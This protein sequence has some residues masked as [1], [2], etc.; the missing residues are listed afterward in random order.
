MH[1]RHDRLLLPILREKWAATEVRSTLSLCWFCLCWFYHDQVAGIKA[2]AHVF[3]STGLPLSQV[4]GCL[5]LHYEVAKPPPAVDPGEA[6]VQIWGVPRDKPAIGYD[7]PPSKGH[8][9]FSSLGRR[10]VSD[11][12]LFFFKTTTHTYTQKIMHWHYSVMG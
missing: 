8:E 4:M 5:S 10:V 7:L 12:F 3:L 11:F 9:P 1:I 2:P 6:Q